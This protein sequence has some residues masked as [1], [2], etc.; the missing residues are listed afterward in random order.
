MNEW[1]PDAL[2]PFAL[3]ELL[4]ERAA[5]W[6]TGFLHIWRHP[7]A[8]I[9]GLRDSRLPGARQA[10]DML[11]AR[12]FSAVVRNSGGAAVPLDLGVVNISL[13]LP[14]RQDGA[15]DFRG[16]FELMYRLIAG[17][18]AHFDSD[19]DKGEIA[20]SYCPGDYDVSIGGR[21]FC[22]LAQRRRQ[23]AYAVQAFVVVEGGGAERAAL[24]RDF[25]RIAADG[26][27]ADRFPAVEQGRM[28]SLSELLAPM[29]AL[30]FADS[31]AA[32]LQRGG[33]SLEPAEAGALAAEAEVSSIMA[34]LK[35][36]YPVL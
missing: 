21:K 13:V 32:L 15:L 26:A 11:R 10:M 35:E 31:F 1:N 19:V 30:Q 7:G 5:A 24:A 16:D 3:D 18:L 2:Y 34:A 12:G 36:R 29:T 27:S 9:M 20:G 8:L 23:H 25:Y 28:A 17:A 4:C 22:G 6:Q 14:K 33:V